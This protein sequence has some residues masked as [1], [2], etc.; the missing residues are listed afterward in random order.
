VSAGLT[1]GYGVAESLGM[2]LSQLPAQMHEIRYVPGA[3][4]SQTE[5]SH[6]LTSR[7][8]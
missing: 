5:N 7:W 2:I 4:E 1:M 3:V 6:G 8:I